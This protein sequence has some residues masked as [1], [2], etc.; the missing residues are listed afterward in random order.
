MKIGVATVAQLFAFDAILDVRSPAEFADDHVPG[1][2]NTPVL[3]DAQ[4]AEVGTL[5]KQ[6][7]PFA[8][9]RLGGAYVAEAV[10]RHIRTRFQTRPKHWRPL[11][12]CWRGGMRS[13]A[14]STVLRAVGWDAHQLEGG[15]KAF[16]HQ[17][18]ADL[19]AWPA[20]FDWK[21][22]AGPTG[23]A[24][25]RVLQ[26]LARRG[27]QVLDLETLAAHRGSVLG[28]LPGTPQPGQ[29]TLDTR[30][31]QALRGFT[32]DRPVYVEAES[33]KIG[34]LQLPK[35]LVTAM[36]DGQVHPVEAPLAARVDFLLRDYSYWLEQTEDLCSRL[37]ALRMLRGAQA[38]AR[39]QE[40]SVSGRHAELVTALL[41]EHYDPAYR[42]SQ[43]RN[44]TAR[45]A[46]PLHADTL[47][48]AGV[49]ALATALMDRT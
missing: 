4:R 40:W 48:D 32:T 38:V 17:V 9:R 30:I 27:A 22:V 2:E 41:E 24:K 19:D 34:D 36:R 1:A 6:V 39:W 26:A 11:V 7:S 47:D 25:T 31:W 45:L 15:Y 35:A 49:D 3:D 18:L 10:G 20:G 44:F 43:A 14:M 33:R 5:Y 29:R 21:V 12:M 42:T 13:G 28:S 37:D 8:A 16:R 46:P 23:S